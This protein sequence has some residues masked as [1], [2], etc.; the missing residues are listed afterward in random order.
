LPWSCSAIQVG[1]R[2]ACLNVV[3][4]HALILLL[5]I[6]LCR[7]IAEALFLEEP[8]EHLYGPDAALLMRQ[9]HNVAKARGVSIIC[10]ISSATNDD[11]RYVDHLVY[12]RDGEAVYSGLAGEPLLDTLAR[13]GI[14]RPLDGPL[15]SYLGKL[16]SVGS[17]SD[18]ARCG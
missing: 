13:H 18:E 6:R 10:R 17:G 4:S 8:L 9:L 11:L 5:Y 3:C 2:G 15:V 7:G 1:D 12:F 14:H 16:H